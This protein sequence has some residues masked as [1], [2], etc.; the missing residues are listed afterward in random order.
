MS[1]RLTRRGFL[2]GSAAAAGAG[3]IVLSD[4][5]SIRAYAQNKKLSV[6]LIGV[7]G[8][9]KAG[10][11][12]ANAENVV[13]ICDVDSSEDR[14]GTG[15]KRWP[16]AKTYTDWRQIYEKHKDLNLVL[17]ATPDH[18]HFPAAYSAVIRGCD[19]DKPRNLAKSVTVE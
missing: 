2:K 16:K 18:T 6:A 3:L 17:V 1:H 9:A 19:V 11:D 15:A 10:H 12:M 14:L 8:Q 13:A 5:L 7:G 4:P